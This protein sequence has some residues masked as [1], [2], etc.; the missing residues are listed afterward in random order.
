MR[1]FAILSFGLHV[2]LLV[3]LVLWFRHHPPAADAPDT[4]GEVELVML[5]QQGT[6]ATVVVPK[7]APPTATKAPDGDN[8]ASRC[9]RNTA[10]ASRTR[11]G[12]RCGR[13]IAAA[14][15]VAARATN[16]AA[17]CASVGSDTASCPA[18]RAEAAC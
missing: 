10:T 14:A 17:A 4:Q 15:T 1:R 7:P 2:A 18:E 6:G 16:T 5:E 9:G 12:Q 11:Q 3:G 8:Q 13:A